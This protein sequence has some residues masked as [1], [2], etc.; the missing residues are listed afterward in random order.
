MRVRLSKKRI[1]FINALVSAKTYAEAYAEAYPKSAGQPR[2]V[3]EDRARKLLKV[4]AVSEE[5]HRLLEEYQNRERQ[6]VGCTRQELISDLCYVRSKIRD[7]IERRED[8][9]RKEC[10]LLH[11]ASPSGMSEHDAHIEAAR[12][13]QRPILTS[14]LAGGMVNA[15]ESLARLLGYSERGEEQGEPVVFSGEEDL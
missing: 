6:R 12:V 1:A 13:L 9:I 8:G 10:S 5:Y 3:L 2:K 11:E 14:A 4:P 7:E 15:V